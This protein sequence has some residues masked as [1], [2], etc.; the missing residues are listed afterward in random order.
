MVAD[1]LRLQENRD[2]IIGQVWKE[3]GFTSLA[4]NRNSAWSKDVKIEVCVPK[5][6][7]GVYVSA[8]G[9]KAI[10]NMGDTEN[11]LLINPA[12]MQILG[13]YYDRYGQ[14]WFK[15]CIVKQP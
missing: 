2:K 5:G 6:T 7:K 11:E 4:V 3:K 13:S 15:A 12:S 1:D 8:R 10:S 14:L 9:G